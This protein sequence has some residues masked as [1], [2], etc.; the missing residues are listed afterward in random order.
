MTE[1]LKNKVKMF[2]SKTG[3]PL[4]Q[5]V[6]HYLQEM[7]WRMFHSIE[8]KMGDKRR[9]LD[10]LC[11][12]IIN[13]RRVEIRISCKKSEKPW[14]LFTE[15][16]HYI[17]YG[18]K[19]KRT[20]VIVNHDINRK[21]PLL[22]KDLFLF[23]HNRNSINFTVMSNGKEARSLMMDGLL[24]PINSVFHRTYPH[25]LTMD[26]RGTIY[27]YLTILDGFLFESFYDPEMDEDVVNYINYGQ[28]ETEMDFSY[29]AKEIIHYSGEYIDFGEINN[30]F[31][32]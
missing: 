1:E 5:R 30:A 22:L 24:S 10:L 28:W 9:E 20:P 16:D 29:H 13:G 26:S 25:E 7:G 31:G 19:L 21:L 11:Y 8:Y 14:I 18:D 32:K 23:K 27:F 4:E 3:Y 2:I 17:K 15:K 12:K 6:G